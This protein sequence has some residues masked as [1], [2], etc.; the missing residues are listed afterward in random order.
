VFV[1]GEQAH[2]NQEGR[3]HAIDADRGHADRQGGTIGQHVP[4]LNHGGSQTDTENTWM[5]QSPKG[6]EAS[7][8]MRRS[9]RG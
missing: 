2:W 8:H 9:L 4:E 1:E 5:Q 6:Y 3:N 7:R